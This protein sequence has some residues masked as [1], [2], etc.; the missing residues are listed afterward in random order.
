MRG[1]FGVINAIL[2]DEV[3]GGADA[4]FGES[5]EIVDDV[6]VVGHGNLLI[7]AYGHPRSHRHRGAH[8]AHENGH[9][10]RSNPLRQDLKRKNYR[11]M[12][13]GRTSESISYIAE[14][15]LV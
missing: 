11:S 12:N 8:P 4:N 7:Q 2:D 10:A 15:I 14:I 1:G 5:V 3:Y 9:Y 13:V 6:R